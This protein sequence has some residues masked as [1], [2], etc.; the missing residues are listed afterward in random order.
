MVNLVS[1]GL[2]IREIDATATVPAVSTSVGAIAGAFKWGPVDEIRLVGSETELVDAFGEPDAATFPYFFSAAQFLQYSNALKVVRVIGSAA[3]NATIGDATLVE[4]GD[5]YESKRSVLAGGSIQTI[6]KYPGAIGNSL[7]IEMCSAHAG[8]FGGWEHKGLFSSV[9]GSSPYARRI[10][11]HAANINTMLDEMHIVV[12]D[13]G[14]AFTG[15]PGTVLETFAFVSQASDAKSDDGTSNYYVDVLNN[16]SEYV[17]AGAHPSA[18]PEAGDTVADT[19]AYTPSGSIIEAGLDGGVDGTALVGDLS[20]GYD[21]LG[22]PQT[23]ELGLIFSGFTTATEADMATHSNKLIALAE[24]RGDC[25]ACVSPPVTATVNAAA[26]AAVTAVT[27]WANALTSSS[28]AVFDS[29]AL[30]VYDKYNDA[31][32][33]ITASGAIAGLCAN[34]DR[35]ADPWFSPAG[36]DRGQI[37]G[38]TKLAYNPKQADR[39]VLYNA[40]VNPIV[41]FPGQGTLLFGDKTALNRPS[42][43]DRINVRR[44]FIELRRSI[45]RAAQ[46]NLFEFNDEFTRAQFRNLVIPYLRDVQG[47]RGITNFEVICDQTNNT[48]QVI[49]ANRFVGDIYIQ[50]ARSI[51]FINLNFIATRT[52]VEFSEIVGR[53]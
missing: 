46:A 3:M 36:F 17:W 47:R 26:T 20:N 25:V 7:R 13:E 18:L 44:L 6:A 10:K 24:G 16:R 1:P 19:S 14:G 45:G 32:R 53:T 33:W 52:G 28:Y 4:N 11:G 49:D 43:F 29:S 34:T 9:P 31:Y 35:V 48:S 27:A 15:T 37:R 12:V 39:D 5:D 42:A 23:E 51:N 8:A 50:P 41:S 38:V 22:D 40:R 21:L 30:Y 2:S